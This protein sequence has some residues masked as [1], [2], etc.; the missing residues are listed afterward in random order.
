MLNAADLLIID[1]ISMV[2][3]KLMEMIRYR[4]DGSAFRGSI[5]FV[6]D[7][8]QLPPIERKDKTTGLSLFGSEVYAFE[9]SA[10]QNWN[11][12]ILELTTSK[13]TSD[14]HFFGLLDRI[15]RGEMDDET[16][17]FLK[18]LRS[19]D[20][21]LGRDPTILF[22]RNFEADRT[23]EQRLR[24]I[25][26]ELYELEAE[27]TINDKSV[28]N[29]RIENWHKSLNIP[30]HLELKVGAN[31][32]FC[33]NKWGKYFNGEQG[34]V[35]AI[36]DEY[37]LV[38]KAG[39]LIKVEP[40]EFALY[41][42]VMDAGSVQNKPLATLRQFPLKLSYAITIHKSQGM[43][44]EQLVCDINHI[45]E[46]SQFYVAISR[47][48]SAAN[49]YLRYN[50]RDFEAHLRRCVAVDERVKEFYERAK[51]QRVVVK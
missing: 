4:I 39:E 38:A 2:S 47:A 33:T 11:P 30:L 13:R 37:I 46:K 9:S 14:R 41:E 6:G 29:S 23:N 1:E 45:F 35:K 16:I 19:N 36:H 51:A 18:G 5:L 8:F 32:I 17:E 44:I 7:F 28:S 50:G 49:L 40:H 42:N 48:K 25:P 34:Q 21:V 26:A 3:A 24:E 20:S 31:V 22:G 43:S 12:K 15:R 10:W 27:Q